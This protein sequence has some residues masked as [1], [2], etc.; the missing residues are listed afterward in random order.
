MKELQDLKDLTMH[1]VQPIGQPLSSE[2]GT[3]SKFLRTFT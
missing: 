2:E 1:D 3:M